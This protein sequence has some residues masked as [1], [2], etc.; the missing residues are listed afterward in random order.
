MVVDIDGRPTVEAATFS[1]KPLKLG[2]RYGIYQS[3]FLHSTTFNTT[4]SEN[5]TRAIKPSE[6]FHA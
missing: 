1:L 3:R 2:A 6:N 5:L 4:P